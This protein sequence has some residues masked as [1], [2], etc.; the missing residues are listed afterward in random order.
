MK[1]LF[2]LLAV[3]FVALASQ[4]QTQASSK[5]KLPV[6]DKSPMDM[7][8]YPSN[9]PVLRI[10][11]KATEPLMARAIYS[12]PQKDNRVIFGNVVEFGKLW[13]LGAN[14]ATEV[15]FYNDVRIGGKKVARG[16]YTLYAIPMAT[17]WTIILNRDT[18]IW[19]AFK[20]DEKKDV[21]RL[22]VPVRKNAEPVEAFTIAFDKISDGMN[23][24]IAWDDVT[25]ALPVSFK[26]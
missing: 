19:G 8:Y 12:R 22:N 21:V 2:S 26:L 17:Q 16:R 13:R 25:V 24:I 18:D 1:H 4:A 5:L 20:Y 9:Y 6:L 3:F 14:E 15:E 11:E 23:L 7:A 10:Q